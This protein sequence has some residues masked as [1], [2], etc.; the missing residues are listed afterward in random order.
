MTEVEVR[1]DSL[2]TAASDMQ[3]A[4]RLITEALEA[5]QAEVAALYALGLPA[6][7]VGA[8]SANYAA[9]AG[10]MQEWPLKLTSFATNFEQAQDEIQQAINQPVRPSALLEL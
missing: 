6:G 7:G 1:L 9:N 2:W 4:G 3:Q 5:V 8:Y 10:L